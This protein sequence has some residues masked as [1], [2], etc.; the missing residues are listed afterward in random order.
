MRALGAAGDAA[1]LDHMP[2]QAQIGEVEPHGR[3]PASL[4]I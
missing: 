2:E 4:R 3:D 1:G